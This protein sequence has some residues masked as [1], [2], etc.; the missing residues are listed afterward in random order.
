MKISG[1]LSAI[2]GY[3]LWGILP[4]YWKQLNFVSPEEILAHRIV[5]SLVFLAV[6][7]FFRRRWAWI[8]FLLKNK[9]TLLFFLFSALVIGTNWFIYIYAVNNNFIVEASLGYFINPLLNVVLGVLIFKERLSKIQWTAVLLAFISVAYL[10][11]NYGRVPW[12][13]LMLA[14][15]FGL[16]GLLR[17][18]G[19]LDSM[20]GLFVEMLFLFLPAM[21]YVI[22]LEKSGQAVFAHTAFS[23]NAL[24]ILSGAVTML[25]LLFFTYA[26]KRVKLAT[27]GLLQYLAP[28]LQFLIGIFVYNEVFTLREFIGFSFLWAALALYSYDLLRKN[29]ARKAAD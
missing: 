21:L 3:L 27:L 13:A 28:T 15:L 12:I 29:A 25:P 6:L 8:G 17:K 4:V 10:T 14:A 11:V 22:Y 2:S 7:L 23:G 16:Y 9:K 24:L 20:D 18:V 26:A 5:W 19:K 1:N